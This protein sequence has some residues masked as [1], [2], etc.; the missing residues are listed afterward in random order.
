MQ[1]RIPLKPNKFGISF[2]FLLS[3]DQ[4]RAYLA[5]WQWEQNRFTAKWPITLLTLL[6]L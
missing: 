6:T 5:H 3:V 2:F 1:A 4:A